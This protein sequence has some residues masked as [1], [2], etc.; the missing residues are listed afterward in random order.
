MA[1]T[2]QLKVNEMAGIISNYIIIISSFILFVNC[3][4]KIFY[5]FCLHPT[6]SLIMEIEELLF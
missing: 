6:L 5:F 2:V 3:F 1:N 4:L